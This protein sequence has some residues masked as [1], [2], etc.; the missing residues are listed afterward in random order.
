[1]I[2]ELIK[3]LDTSFQLYLV[4]WIFNHFILAV[5][6]LNKIMY[7]S[8]IELAVLMLNRFFNPVT[9]EDKFFI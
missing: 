1:M 2:T 4:H 7:F 3:F 5:V 6:I 9:V 8:K